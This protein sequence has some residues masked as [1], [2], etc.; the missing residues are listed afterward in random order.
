M[1][2]SQLVLYRDPNE[3]VPINVQA[4]AGREVEPPHGNPTCRL[5]SM[6]ARAAF[7]TLR[8]LITCGG[9]LAGST[10]MVALAIVRMLLLVPIGIGILCGLFSGVGWLVVYLVKG[11]SI[12]HAVHWCLGSFAVA[13]TAIVAQAMT[14]VASEWI[15]ER[16]GRI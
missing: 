16:V 10:A 4:L 7:A 13:F 12:P 3:A 8:L 11:E 2:N 15:R 1:A 14:Y 6:L 5:C 9:V